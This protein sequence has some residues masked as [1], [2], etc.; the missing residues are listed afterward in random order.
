M[1]APF[2]FKPSARWSLTALTICGCAS[3]LGIDH[4]YGDLP[5]SSL[6]LGGTDS[7]EGA[8]GSAMARAGTSPVGGS[9]TTTSGAAS[10]SGGIS[11]EASGPVAGSGALPS[12][13]TAG[14]VPA[15]VAGNGGADGGAAAEP[16]GPAIVLESVQT[17]TT[18]IA[19]GSA[20]QSVTIEKVDPAHAFL[21]FGAAFDSTSSSKS[22]LSGQITASTQLTFRRYGSSGAPA[23]PI[24]YYVAHF[25]RGVDVQR[26]SHV[27]TD[28]TEKVPLDAAIDLKRSFPLVSYRNVGSFYGLDDFVRAE[29]TGASELSLSMAQASGNSTVEW[30]VV[31][32]AGARVQS[33]TLDVAPSDSSVEVSPELPMPLDASFVLASYQV[34]KAPGGA[35]DAMIQGSL[36]N[37]SQIVFQRSASGAGAKLTFYAVTLEDGSSV[38]SGTAALSS[39]ATSVNLAPAVDP[40]KSIAFTAGA[41]Q[42]GGTT[43]YSS[44]SNP[45][46]ATFNLDLGSG[47][48]L[49]LSRGPNGAGAELSWY[50]VTFR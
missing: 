29:L 1:N 27:L 8:A 30:Q 32:L 16:T 41:Y 7:A 49:A 48:T 15:E 31:S 28:A 24:H 38:T 18:T 50:A 34:T 47:S 13:G 45:G 20:Q 46:Y 25:S 3:V 23:I 17:G 33:G 43:A 6:P 22:E 5:D 4:D 21:V 14:G 44:S 9:E 39:A 36:S 42:R 19:S 11:G 12:G 40:A 26:G 37:P 10:A 2:T 35:A